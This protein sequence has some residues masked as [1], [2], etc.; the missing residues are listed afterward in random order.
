MDMN[1]HTVVCLYEYTEGRLYK[2]TARCLHVHLA[3]PRLVMERGRDVRPFSLVWS[4]CAASW[5]H[6]SKTNPQKQLSV[7]QDKASDKIARPLLTS[8]PDRVQPWWTAVVV[9]HF[10]QHLTR[11]RMCE[12]GEFLVVVGG[13][14]HQRTAPDHCINSPTSANFN[15]SPLFSQPSPLEKT[16]FSHRTNYFF[17]PPLLTAA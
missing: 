3:A 5:F 16:V 4:V 10:A 2:D 11:L 7:I 12:E 17:P 8:V 15:K 9:R 13:V 1:K 6:F 14:T